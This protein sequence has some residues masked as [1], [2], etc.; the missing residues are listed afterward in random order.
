[1]GVAFENITERKRIEKALVESTRKYRLV[2]NSVKEVIFQTDTEGHWTF[3]NPAWMDIT[4]FTIIDSLKDPFTD[5]IWASED[6]HCCEQVFK[7]IIAGA[8]ESLQCVFR[9]KTKAGNLCWVEM[10]AQPNHDDEDKIIGTSGTLRDITER[11]Q[12]KAALQARAD[13]LAQLN[14]ILLQTTAQLKKRN[15][16]LDQFAYVTSHDLKAPLRAIANLSEWLEEDLEDKLAIA[17]RGALR[18]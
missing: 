13:E 1:M 17:L 4:G 3:L 8:A 6:Q 18:S 11:Q 14:R 5:Y 7:S 15:Q 12:A 2:V 9:I 10:N 16:E